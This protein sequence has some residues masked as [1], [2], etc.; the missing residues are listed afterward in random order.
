MKVSFTREQ[1]RII[2]GCVLAYTTAYLI[3]LN[4]SASISGV[5]AG[6]GITSTQA[7]LL[8]TCFAIMY[9][10]GQLINGAV[11]DRV[12]PVK[13]IEFG[14][15]G[16]IACNICLGLTNVYW[17]MLALCFLNGAF[18]SMLWTPIVRL[19]ASRFREEKSRFKANFMLS[20]TLVIGHFAAWAVAGFFSEAIGWRMSF[21]APACIAVL[22]LVGV[23][24][25]MRGIRPGDE[26]Q[27][28]ADG[29]RAGFIDNMKLF[30]RT[31]FF[32]LILGCVF[33]G[34]IKD[35]TVTWA[36]SILASIGGADNPLVV[37][38]SLIIPVINLL[39]ILAGQYLRLHSKGSNRL[40]TAVMMPLAAAFSIPLLFRLGLVPT[41]LF[42]G[43]ACAVV[44]GMNPILTSLVPMEYDTFGCAGLAA[45]MIDSFIYVGSAA[46]GVIEGGLKEAFGWDSLYISWIAV[47]VV[48]T[49]LIVISAMK[50]FEKR[51]KDPDT[52]R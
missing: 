27:A 17:L 35:G 16:S 5:M 2:Y 39:G 50:R 23:Y 52:A 3:R 40:S 25:I 37:S 46:S 19:V 18:Q 15:I 13:Y 21:I 34:F 14:L 42:I 8:Q 30:A 38:S 49:G 33:Y 26:V 9:A 47:S 41:A 29:R 24:F 31:G 22:S 45:G 11:V 6:L 4:L 12:D 43:L 36:P 28:S 7:G 20:L 44:Y 1:K 51:M 10:A 48:A 32:P